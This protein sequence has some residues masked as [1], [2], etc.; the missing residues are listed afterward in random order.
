MGNLQT[1][2]LRDKV[3]QYC[4]SLIWKYDSGIGMSRVAQRGLRETQ[5][6]YPR[7]EIPLKWGDILRWIRRRWWFFIHSFLDVMVE[8]DAKRIKQFEKI[9]QA[10]SANKV[11]ES[12]LFIHEEIKWIR[13]NSRQ[14]EDSQKMIR[15]LQSFQASLTT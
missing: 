4:R 3:L 10:V 14:V 1:E 2:Q 15:L 9:I 8:I 13:R 11:P 6:L 12:Y 5:N 7:F